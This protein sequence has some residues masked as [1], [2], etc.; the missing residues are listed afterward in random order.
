MLVRLRPVVHATPAPHGLHLRGWASSCTI[1]GG[2]GLWQVWQRLAPQLSAGIPVAELG[3]PD[4]TAPAVRAAVELI[5]EQL[6]EHD[7]LV[8]VPAWSADG[9]PPAVAEWLESVAA[10]PV[11]AWR[12]LRPVTISGSGPLVEAAAR[13]ADAVGLKIT[14][15]DGNTDELVVSAGDL[16]VLAGCG[17]D[18]GY[19]LPIGTD[20]TSFNTEV[21]TRITTRLGVTG[22]PAEVLAALIGSASVHRLICALAGLPDPADTTFPTA[23]VA[24]INPLRAAYHP[25]STALPE[26]DPWRVLDA[27]TDPELGEADTPVF[28][29]LP[30]VPANLALCGHALG[31]GTTADAARLNAVLNALKAD[32]LDSLHAR[33]TALRR[34]ARPLTG[35]PVPAAGWTANPTA[36]RW[37]KALTV[38]FAVPASLQVEQLAQGAYKAEIRDHTQVLSWAVEA[39]AQDAVA[40]AALAATGHAQAGREGTAHLNGAAPHQVEDHW[41]AAVRDRE[42]TLQQTLAALLGGPR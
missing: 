26:A 40:F 27:L 7:M 17:A 18:V 11:G 25:L 37:W 36:H 10:D 38:R 14:R 28:G 29:A 6:R 13:A 24:R 5:L 41:P 42:A 33:G 15:G 12:R 9:P 20:F 19:V 8:Q 39:T 31:I 22:A 35:K 2:A 30:Q 4:G 3:V 21:T 34:A 16:V 1:T 32:G 23:L